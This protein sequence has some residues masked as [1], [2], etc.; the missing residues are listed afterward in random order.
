MVLAA[1]FWGPQWR[2]K[3]VHF[4]C[5]NAAIVYAIKSG[6]SR[7]PLLMQLP[8]GL[9][10]FAMKH[11]FTLSVSHIAENGPADSLSHNKV[12]LFLSQVPQAPPV[13]ETLHKDLL[14]LFLVE[15]PPDWLSNSWRQQLTSILP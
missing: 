5:D 13:P 3:A 6:K 7:E 8:H 15:A 14:Q 10:L 9:H 12:S 2:G 1:A 4:C 11:G